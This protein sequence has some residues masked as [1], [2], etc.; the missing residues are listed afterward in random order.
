MNHAHSIIVAYD[1]NGL[2]S[3]LNVAEALESIA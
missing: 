1:H 3:A 2:R